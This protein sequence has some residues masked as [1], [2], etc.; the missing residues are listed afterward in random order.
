MDIVGTDG[1]NKGKTILG[2]YELK[3]DTL[4]ICYDLTGKGRPTE[5]VTKKDAPLFLVVYKRAKP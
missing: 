3:E 1:P 5:F 2:I 4:R